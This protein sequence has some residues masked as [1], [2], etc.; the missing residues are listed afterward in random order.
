ML[1]ENEYNRLYYN[2]L[3]NNIT[4]KRGYNYLDFNKD[5]CNIRHDEG[6]RIQF[7]QVFDRKPY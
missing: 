7:G 2:S 4:I 1:R 6:W 5:C 3:C